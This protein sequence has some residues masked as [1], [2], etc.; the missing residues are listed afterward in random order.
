MKIRLP[1]SEIEFKDALQAAAELAT[2]TTLT[3]LGLLKPY[4]SLNQAYKMYGTGTVERWHEEGLI[5]KIK[6]G[7]G[8]SPVRI[9]R[10]EIEAVA[11]TSNRAEWYIRQYSEGKHT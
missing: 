9:S 8:K 3:K 7:E 4:I 1:E 2:E 6:D 10:V 5:K 11:K